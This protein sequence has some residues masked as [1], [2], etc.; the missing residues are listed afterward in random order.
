MNQRPIRLD[1]G[2]KAEVMDLYDGTFQSIKELAKLFGVSHTNI[3][4]LVDYKDFQKKQDE[5]GKKWKKNNP[6][7]CKENNKRYHQEH[8]EEINQR[9]KKYYQ[10]RKHKK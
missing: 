1:E 10:E 6:E 5:R 7:R 4:W 3:R 9:H 2:Q 8:K